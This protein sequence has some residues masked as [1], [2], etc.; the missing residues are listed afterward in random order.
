MMI[1]LDPLEAFLVGVAAAFAILHFMLW[2]F[3]REDRGNLHLAVAAAAF[4]V[5][6]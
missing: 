3:R 5:S 6:T 1:G 4:A 2:V